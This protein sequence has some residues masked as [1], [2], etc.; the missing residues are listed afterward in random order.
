MVTIFLV[1]DLQFASVISVTVRKE[2]GVN[3]IV[4]NAQSWISC[5]DICVLKILQWNL[6]IRNILLMCYKILQVLSSAI[7]IL[8]QKVSK[9]IK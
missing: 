3:S 5:D 2:E 7:N 8:S 1:L 9:D 6:F 4:T